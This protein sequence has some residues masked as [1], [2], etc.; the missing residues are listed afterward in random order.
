VGK[1]LR[2]IATSPWSAD[3]HVYDPDGR[4]IHGLRGVEIVAKAGKLATVKLTAYAQVDVVAEI[5]ARP[6]MT[7]DHEPGDCGHEGCPGQKWHDSEHCRAC[8][9]GVCGSA[10]HIG[11]PGCVP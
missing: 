10:D 3:W 4:E 8:H 7:V 2:I 5:V 1:P 11:C 6:G 9:D